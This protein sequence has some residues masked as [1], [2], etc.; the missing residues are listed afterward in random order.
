M[1][2][3]DVMNVIEKEYPLNYALSWDNVGLLVGRDDKEVKKIYIALDATDEVIDEAVKNGAD[4]LI[5]HHPMIFSPIKKIHNLDFVGGRILKLIQE[6]T[7]EGDIG[8][9]DEPE[10]IGRVSDLE[11]PMTLRECCED[12]KDA[13]HLGTVK[14]F[15]NL[16][17]KVKRIAI[18][19]GSGKSVIQAALDKHADVLITGDI[20]HHEGIDAVAQGLAIID[21]GHYGIEH[22]FIEDMRQYLEKNLKDVEVIAAPIIHPF[23]LV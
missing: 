11:I 3:R 8:E 10:G 16:E 7:A 12:V 22:I 20:G 2:C 6:V 14:V 13:F 23:L 18:C 4:M 1:L 5:T 21:G 19:P 15:G 9:E 17:D